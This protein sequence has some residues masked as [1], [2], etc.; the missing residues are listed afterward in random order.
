MSNGRPERNGA[1]S[2]VRRGDNAQPVRSAAP[3]ERAD[4]VEISEADRDLPLQH[5]AHVDRVEP[6]SRQ[7]VEALRERVKKGYYDAP[8]VIDRVVQRLLDSGELGRPAGP[9]GT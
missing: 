5:L 7:R 2:E 1:A 8:D 4:R 6:L 3:V 9:G